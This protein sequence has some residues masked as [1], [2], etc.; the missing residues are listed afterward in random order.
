ME[1]FSRG[2][3]SLAVIALAA[4]DGRAESVS[5]DFD[6]EIGPNFTTTNEGEFWTIGVVSGELRMS[7]GPDAGTPNAAFQEPQFTRGSVRSVFEVHGDFEVTVDFTLYDFTL[8]PTGPGLTESILGAVNAADPTNFFWVL[9]F[10]NYLEAFYQFPQSAIGA[11]S[12]AQM[13]GRYRVTRTGTTFTGWVAPPGSS[14]FV[15][16]GTHSAFSGPAHVDLLG[17][18]GTPFFHSPGPRGPIDIAFD[19]LEVEADTVVG[20]VPEPTI[21][22]LCAISVSAILVLRRRTRRGSLLRVARG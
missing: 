3:L 10:D 1:W 18:Q 17:R 14:A 12:S 4:L 19:N 5:F 16:I 20:A 22:L 7:K 13:S 2:I 21:L 15:A 8:P 11:R 6:T 9:R